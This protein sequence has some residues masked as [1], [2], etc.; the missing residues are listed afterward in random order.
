MALHR[1]LAV[2]ISA[3][4]IDKYHEIPRGSKGIDNDLCERVKGH[5]YVRGHLDHLL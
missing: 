3:I 4:Y 2:V 1:N 5:L